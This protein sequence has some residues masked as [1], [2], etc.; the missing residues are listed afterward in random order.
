MSIQIPLHMD[1]V[2]LEQICLVGKKVS[3]WCRDITELILNKEDVM[4]GEQKKEVIT[5]AVTILYVGEVSGVTIYLFCDTI[6]LEEDKKVKQHQ[7]YVPSYRISAVVDGICVGFGY[8]DFPPLATFYQVVEEK[9]KVDSL[10]WAK[11]R[12]ERQKEKSIEE[13]YA[14]ALKRFQ[15]L[16]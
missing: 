9:C 8:S 5:K 13:K 7:K 10:K 4:V 1:N 2:T 15:S 11:H 3:A 16:C 6:I 12:A 14:S